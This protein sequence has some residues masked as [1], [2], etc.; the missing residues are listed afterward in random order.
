MGL[1]LWYSSVTFHSL[2]QIQHLVYVV[3]RP[4]RVKY[5]CWVDRPI[6]S[7]VNIVKLIIL[8]DAPLYAYQT[9]DPRI[10]SRVYDQTKPLYFSS[11]AIRVAKRDEKHPPR[12]LKR[13]ANEAVK[14]Y[15]RISDKSCLTSVSVSIVTPLWNTLSCMA[16]FI[17]WQ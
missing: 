12:S 11:L 2:C 7:A 16:C 17:V 6:C 4:I 1:L 8:F 13:R 5:V 15:K 9:I 14:D 3:Y 10:S